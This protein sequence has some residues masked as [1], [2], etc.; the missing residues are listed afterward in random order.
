M[1]G[2]TSP[3]VSRLWHIAP[4]PSTLN[5]YHGHKDDNDANEDDDDG[6]DDDDNMDKPVQ[7]Q[8]AAL[9]HDGDDHDHDGVDHD[10]D[11]VDDHGGQDQDDH[12]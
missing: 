6:K 1:K 2:W 9:R 4:S 12:E 3:C 11:G 5:S 8:V 10:H 7:T